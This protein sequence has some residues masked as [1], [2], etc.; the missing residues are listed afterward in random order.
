MKPKSRKIFILCC[1]L[2]VFSGM[3]AQSFAVKTNLLYWATLTPNISIEAKLSKQ[4]TTDLQA[5]YNPFTLQDGK[6]LKFWLA[7]PELRYWFCDAF[8]GHFLGVHLH[9]AQFY[10]VPK[11]KVYDGYLAGGG[12]TY[13]YNWILSPRWNLEALIGVGYA[14]LWYKEYPNIDCI[15][16]HED[17]TKDYIG[18]TKVALTVSYIF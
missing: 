5:A 13:G 1:F 12:L 15:K 11:D 16:C 9:A 18:P 2:L 17:K 3:R 7:Q 4:F 14:H 10:A 6:K 8:E